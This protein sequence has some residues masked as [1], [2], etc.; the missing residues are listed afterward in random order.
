MYPTLV[1]SPGESIDVRVDDIIAACG[2]WGG[3]AGPCRRVL[4]AASPGDPVELELVR[5]DSSQPMGLSPD[6]LAGAYAPVS[7]LTMPPGGSPYVI[8][9]GTATLTARR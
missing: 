7:R 4:V 9:A 6:G 2:E 3:D 1:I 5:V 8:G